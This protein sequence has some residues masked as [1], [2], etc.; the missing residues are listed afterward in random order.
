MSSSFDA[1]T[2][3]ISMILVSEVGDK[4]FLIAAILAMRHPRMTVFVGAFASLICMSILSAALGHVLPHFIPRLWTQALAGVLF[5]GFGSRMLMEA[6]AMKNDEIDEEMREAEADIDGLDIGA[7][8]L[9]GAEAGYLDYSTEKEAEPEYR[10]ARPSCAPFSERARDLF[11]LCF[12]AV[13]VETFILTFVAE[14]GDRSQIATI[15]LGSAHSMWVVSA[16]T[17]M[18]HACCSALAVVCGRWLS[19]RI[20]LKQITLSGAC[21]FLVFGVIYICQSVPQI[22]GSW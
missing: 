14:W 3:S 1:F 19:A 7:N 18:G 17:I 10:P 12:G 8:S 6:R 9:K 4:T 2:Q 5:I 22:L 20:S 16:G 13:F 11:S 21:L 15:A